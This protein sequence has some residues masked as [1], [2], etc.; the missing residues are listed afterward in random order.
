MHTSQASRNPWRAFS[1]ALTPWVLALMLLVA[2]APAVSRAMGVA[3][4]APGAGPPSGAAFAGWVE[5]CGPGGVR[6]VVLDPSAAHGGPGGPDTP[7]PAGG[8]V[9]D[10]AHCALCGLGLDRVLPPHG[11]APQAPEPVALPFAP[12]H[13]VP[14]PRPWPHARPR[15]TGPPFLS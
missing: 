9:A 7:A 15:A 13:P 12:P 10:L 2:L 6:W 11:H 8:P 1:R 3:G 14:A 4:L 5:V